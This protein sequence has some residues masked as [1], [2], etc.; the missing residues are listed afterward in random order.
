MDTRHIAKIAAKIVVGTTV[1]SFV[2]KAL[3]ANIPQTEK[4]KTAEMTG[5]LVGAVTADKLQPFTDKLVDDY[6]DRRN[7]KKN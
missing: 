2:T 3:I 4:L 7:A 6:F 1:G 5:L